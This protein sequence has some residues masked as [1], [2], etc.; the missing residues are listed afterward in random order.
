M[1]L[2]DIDVN[3]PA[4]VVEA[5][6]T[7]TEIQVEQPVEETPKSAEEPAKESTEEPGKVQEETPAPAQEP[8]QPKKSRAQ[9]RIRDLSRENRELQERIQQFS[10]QTA[11]EF[12]QDEISHDDL[13]RVI[14]ERAMQAAE[15]IVA[16]Q[17]VGSQYQNQ[18]KA[19]ADDFDAVKAE[20]PQLDPK[21]PDYDP[22][23]DA[24]LARLM[25]SGDGTP[26]VDILVS[27]VLKTLR[28]R[29]EATH[30]K[31]K[32]EGKSEATVKLA[33]QMAEGAI[34]PTTKTSS[35]AKEYS[36]EELEDMRVNRPKEYMK[37]ID[38]I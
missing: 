14:N 2:R 29:E 19:W 9:E 26:R 31:A 4:E 7:E 10:Q 36:D 30:T 38:K 17:Q 8:E 3:E 5:S 20:N 27:D 32:E 16:S 12:Q 25:D 11:P 22:E 34:T 35:E 21:S 18:I 24:T 1:E 28:R 6:T 15:L 13:N 37:I 23:L 33:K